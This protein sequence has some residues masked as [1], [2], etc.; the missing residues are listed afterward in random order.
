MGTRRNFR[1]NLSGRIWR[2]FHR[3]PIFL[4]LACGYAPVRRGAAKGIHVAAVRNDTAQAEAGG[5]FA[6]ELRAELAGRG[7][8]DPDGA[9]GDELSAELVSI[10]SVPTAAGAD[11]ALAFAVSAV[12]KVRVGAWEDTAA[13]SEDYASGVDVLG[14]EANRRAALRRLAR[15]LAKEAIERYDVA[16]R[17]K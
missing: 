13:G 15:T 4:C 1:K 10:T 6:Q 7:R 8:L 11:G 3:V 9:P 14:T 2:K 17:L 12:L 5:W 16:D